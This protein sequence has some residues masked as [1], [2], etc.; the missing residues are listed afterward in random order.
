MA[1]SP[2]RWREASQRFEALVEALPSEREAA[3]AELRQRDPELAGLV[4]R[5]LAE[6]EAAAVRWARNADVNIKW[7]A[8]RVSRAHD[9][10]DTDDVI[11]IDGEWIS[12]ED[13]VVI[14]G[15]AKREEERRDKLAALKAEVARL[16]KEGGNNE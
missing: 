7:D 1:L 14:A 4:S 15:L 3:L 16:L 9:L 6:D 2:E 13:A 10:E 12:R 8:Y 5:L 11:G